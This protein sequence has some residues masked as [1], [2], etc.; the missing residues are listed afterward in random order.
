MFRRTFIGKH[1]FFGVSVGLRRRKHEVQ[2][3]STV[4]EKYDDCC[5]HQ[6]ALLSLNKM[7]TGSSAVWLTKDLRSDSLHR[8]QTK[9]HVTFRVLVNRWRY[10]TSV[11]QN[12]WHPRPIWHHIY[13]IY[14]ICY[15]L[16][17]IQ[18][19]LNWKT[20][21]CTYKFADIT[22]KITSKTF[23][24]LGISYEYVFIFCLCHGC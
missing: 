2:R 5:D 15:H 3:I 20:K 19:W 6:E 23:R 12:K 7:P 13:H 11:I 10:V 14:H 8:R 9:C 18:I 22:I 24:N 4:C 16:F 1:S 17:K 21:H